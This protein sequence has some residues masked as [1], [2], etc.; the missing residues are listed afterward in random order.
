MRA[1]TAFS[2]GADGFSMFSTVCWTLETGQQAHA[3]MLN[4]GWSTR[5]VLQILLFPHQTPSGASELNISFTSA[6]AAEVCG[7]K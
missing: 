6:P 7:I 3:E 4:L 2:R 5:P 1:D